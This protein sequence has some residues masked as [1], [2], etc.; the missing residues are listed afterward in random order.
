LDETSEK[1]GS[2]VAIPTQF[3]VAGSHSPHGRGLSD[4]AFQHDRRLNFVG[5]L[6]DGRWKRRRGKGHSLWFLAI[7]H[8]FLLGAL[9]NISS[10]LSSER[11]LHAFP[12]LYAAIQDPGNSPWR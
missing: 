11:V 2:S 8:R 7:L 6:S 4:R 5:S 12:R 1:G 3:S 10:R 9:A